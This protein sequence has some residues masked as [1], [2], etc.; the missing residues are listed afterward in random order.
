MKAFGY[1][2]QDETE[3]IGLAA[4]LKELKREGYAV[5]PLQAKRHVHGKSSRRWSTLD[6]HAPREGVDWK[7]LAGRQGRGAG[8]GKGPLM[9]RKLFLK[10]VWHQNYSHP[11]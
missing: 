7:H 4:A 8:S 10:N 3:W 11:Q 5:D 6:G 2:E 9:V 1:K